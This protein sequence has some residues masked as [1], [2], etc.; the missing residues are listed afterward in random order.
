MY[1]EVNYNGDNRMTSYFGGICSI[2]LNNV[3]I[4]GIFIATTITIVKFGDYE[5]K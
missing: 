3:L 2:L 1:I 5:I 4:L